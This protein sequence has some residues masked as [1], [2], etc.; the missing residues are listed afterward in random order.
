MHKII[1]HSKVNTT[2]DIFFK[3]QVKIDKVLINKEKTI[4]Q[5][6]I[7]LCLATMAKG[8]WESVKRFS[9]KLSTDLVDK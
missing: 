6:M 8:I 1:F 9:T 7:S 5:K 3:K 2:I 4:D